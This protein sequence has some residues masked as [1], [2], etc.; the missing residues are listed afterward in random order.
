MSAQHSPERIHTIVIGGGQ[1]GLSVGYYL[2]QRGVD[3]AILDANTRVGDAWR[4]RWDSLRLFTTAKFDGLPGLR[5]PADPNY[6]PTKDEMAAYLESYAS[7]FALP[8][9]TGTRVTRL[10]KPAE[11]FL[12]ETSNGSLEADQVVVAMA[13]YQVPVTPSFAREL[14][15]RI[16]QIQSVDYRNP[17]QLAEGGVLVVGAGNSGAEIALDVSHGHRVSLAGPD[18][19]QVP[20]HVDG[21]PARLFL[22][23]LLMRVLFHRVLTVDT[24]IGR[25]VRRLALHRAA[26]LIRTRRKTLAAAGI[27]R[28]PRVAGVT[29]GKPTLAD[30]QVLDDVTNVIW[31]AGYRPG[32]SWIDLPI[33]DEHGEPRHHRGIVETQPG[34]YFVGLHFLYAFSS[35]MIHGVWR[36]AERV[37]AAVRAQETEVRLPNRPVAVSSGSRV[38]AGV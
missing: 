5:F 36:D 12:V 15:P 1:A 28:V 35:T 17:S 6:F 9:R 21:W 34:L 26:P 22:S 37:A 32:F 19:G 38:A 31:C 4:H 33:L 8:I 3:F 10:S 29:A 16:R 27:A 7:H 13:S 14:D 23:R 2:K 11:R 18:T 20:F 24:P 30:G 25:R